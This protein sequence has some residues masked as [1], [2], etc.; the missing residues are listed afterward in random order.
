MRLQVGIEVEGRT[1]G[2][3][4][5]MVLALG[6]NMGLVEALAWSMA[7]IVVVEPPC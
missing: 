5:V 2:L 7:L 1:G 3:L 4:L 6:R